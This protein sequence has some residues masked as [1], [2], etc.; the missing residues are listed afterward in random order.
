[1]M[2]L[3]SERLM[4]PKEVADAFGVGTKTISRWAAQGK[5]KYTVTLGGH[6]RYDRQHVMMLLMKGTHK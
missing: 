4:S 5:L 2:L 6:R 3:S 1:M